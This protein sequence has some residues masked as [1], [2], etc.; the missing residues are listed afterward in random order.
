MRYIAAALI[1]ILAVFWTAGALASGSSQEETVL[2]CRIQGHDREVSV[3]IVGTRATYR[4][5]S[6]LLKPEMTLSSPLADLDYRRKNGP[7][8]TID[9][10]VTFTNG[11]TAYRITAGF[12]NGIA[13]DPSALQPFGTLTVTRTG[14]TL[15]ALSCRPDS[16]IRVHDR[17]L[18]RMR[19]IGRERSSDGESLPN[20]EIQYPAPANQSP[21]CKQ[22]FNVDTCWSRG[23]GAARGGDLRGALGHY[24]KSCEAG[25]NELGCY[26]AGK[27]YLQNRQL[28]DYAKAQ[29]RFT[30]VCDG[31]DPGR[32][33]YACKYLGWMHLTA[34]GVSRDLDKAWSRLALACFL[35]NDADMIDPEGCHFFAKTVAA[36]RAAAPNRYARADFLAYVALS[37]ACTDDARTV[38]DEARALY[39]TGAGQHAPWIKSCDAVVRA[40]RTFS[41]CEEMARFRGDYET[42]MATR[43]NL[44]AMFLAALNNLS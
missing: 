22:D 19:E 34:T 8:D 30:R 40:N 13:P 17:F 9:E 41:S 16:I 21:P 31:D 4:Y 24:D 28:R 5:G 12:R 27:L 10:I 44:K 1:S 6:A 2:T 3:S 18:A 20:Y 11:D 42:A 38:C 14:K 43:R 32:G 36:V 29:E 39:R 33:P 23:V 15:T 25:F 7:G 37:Q 26:E 35:H